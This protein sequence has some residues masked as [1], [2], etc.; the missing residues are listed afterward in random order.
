[1]SGACV[2]HEPAG[3][4]CGW[5]TYAA[6]GNTA[7]LSLLPRSLYPFL[8]ILAPSCSSRRAN[9]NGI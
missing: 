9:S 7:V 4:S 6:Q 5:A 1:M 2:A 3:F 8:L